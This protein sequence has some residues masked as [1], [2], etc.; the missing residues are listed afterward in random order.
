MLHIGF[1]NPLIGIQMK[2]LFVFLSLLFLS[3]PVIGQ[4]TGVLYQY[5]TSSGI[6]WKTFGD[7]KVQP[8]YKGEIKNGK[9]D[10]KRDG[11]GTYSVPDGG[12]TI[13]EFKENPWN[14]IDYDKDGNILGKYVNGEY[15]STSTS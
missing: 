11:Q 1:P 12:E 3:S 10:G 8:K 15:K 14:T 7:G 9:M 5:E 6:Q 13:G 4:E 2:H